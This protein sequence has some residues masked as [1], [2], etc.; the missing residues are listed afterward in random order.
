MRSGTEF[1]T[2]LLLLLD[3]VVE[4]WMGPSR[5][6]RPTGRGA[7]WGRGEGGGV[8]YKKCLTASQTILLLASNLFSCVLRVRI[9]TYWSSSRS[10]GPNTYPSPA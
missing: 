3:G 1:L 4:P 2:A 8:F 7:K 10:S 9:W 5:S 6:L